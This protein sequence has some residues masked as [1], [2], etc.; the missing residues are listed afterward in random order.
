MSMLENEYPVLEMTVPET[1][2][3][4]PSP[5]AAANGR[6]CSDTVRTVTVVHIV[7][8]TIEANSE[9]RMAFLASASR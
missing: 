1:Q 7:R 5:H 6:H 3:P 2:V 9:I 8:I 4:V